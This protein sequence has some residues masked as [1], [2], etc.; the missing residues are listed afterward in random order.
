MADASALNTNFVK[1]FQKSFFQDWDKQ[2]VTIL[3]LSIFVEAVIIFIVAS[4]P[5]DIYSEQ[6]ISRI[7]ERYVNFVLKEELIKEESASKDGP[8]SQIGEGTID[9]GTAA[10]DAVLEKGKGGQERGSGTGDNAGGRGERGTAGG[11]EAAR[12]AA[13]EARRIS[14]E[15]IS[16]EVS[17]KGLLGL[18]TGTGSA[19]QGE[20]VSDFFTDTGGRVGGAGSDLDQVLSNVD[21][22]KIQGSSGLGEG[23]GGGRGGQTARGSRSNKNASI[24]D[25][26]SDLGSAGS[27]QLSRSGELVVEA[28]SEVGGMG[29]KSIY[30]S[31]DA[32]H[33][34]LLSH[35]PAVRYCYERELK[36]NPELK[37]KIVVKITVAADGSVSEAEIVSSTLNSER[38]ER[39]I[40]ARIR[41]WKDFQAIDPREGDVTFRQ[42]Y[43]FGY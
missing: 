20:A 30:R 11:R 42:V 18:I 3:F 10:G 39:C 21:G 9:K 43:T 27:G 5:V 31:P 25:L 33:E 26:V 40:L 19:A 24:D 34:V 12:V 1:E 14:R 36:R 15:Q 35:V 7:Q 6:E 22:L 37:G 23:G 38:V 17:S 4:R 16:Q 29:R 13:T 2:F 28:P 8:V 32:I 41:L